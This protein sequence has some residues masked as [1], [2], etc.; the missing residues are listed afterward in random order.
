MLPGLFSCLLGNSITEPAMEPTV[1][2]SFSSM[3]LQP[4]G[5]LWKTVLL[6]WRNVWTTLKGNCSPVCVLGLVCG[7]W[8]ILAP[9]PKHTHLEQSAREPANHICRGKETRIPRGAE[10]NP[11]SF[12]IKT[13][14]SGWFLAWEE[15]RTSRDHPPLIGNSPEEREDLQQASYLFWYCSLLDY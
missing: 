2:Y 15:I 8:S 14:S 11:Y 3:R 13:R 4:Q 7:G 9:P 10:K 12:T 5:L 6:S 1:L